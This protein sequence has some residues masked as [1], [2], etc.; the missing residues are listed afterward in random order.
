MFYWW[1]WGVK[2]FWGLRTESVFCLLA[3]RR[4]EELESVSTGHRKQQDT[5]YNLISKINQVGA[6]SSHSNGKSDIFL[7]SSPKTVIRLVIYRVRC[8]IFAWY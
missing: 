5:R 7:F 1:F 6:S 3:R 8:I 2:V 4:L